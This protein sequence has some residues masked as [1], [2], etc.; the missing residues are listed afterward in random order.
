MDQTSGDYSYA[1]GTSFAAPVVSGAAALKT[2]WFR[3]RGTEPKAT[4]LKAALIATADS[5]GPV[6]NGEVVCYDPGPDPDPN[7]DCRPSHK[8][9]WGLVN[10]DRLTEASPTRFIRNEHI[11]FDE[12]GDFWRSVF[13][14]ADDPAKPIFI[15]LVWND[16]PNQ[17]GVSA[18]NL[19]LKRDLSLW[20]E[21]WIGSTP[22]SGFWAG[23]SFQENT[24]SLDTGW[25]QPFGF[26]NGAVADTVN[27]VEAV[28]IPPNAGYGGKDG[29]KIVVID[30]AHPDSDPEEAFPLQSFSI[31]AWNAK[32]P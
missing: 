31:Y 19:S 22:T 13:L 23:N 1:R 5:L 18:T 25:S 9:G 32:Q 8:S 26:W 28:F 11:N 16:I 30:E 20:V 21:D 17:T 2:K 27:T 12:V 4:L 29:F 7:A 24:V 10:L 14:T 6:V 3:N 15:V